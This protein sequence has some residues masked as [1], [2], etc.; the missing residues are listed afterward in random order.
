MHER[1]VVEL[2]LEAV[3]GA[4]SSVDP[5]AIDDPEDA[6]SRTIGFLGHHLGDERVEGND[7]DFLD[8]LAEELR[9]M[10]VPSCD[11]RPNVKTS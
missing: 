5:A 4:L 3:H 8:D 2:F 10:R 7:G 1:E 9:P 11:V 6:A